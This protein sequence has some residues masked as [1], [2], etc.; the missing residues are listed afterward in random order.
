MSARVCGTVR[1]APKLYHPTQVIH[2]G[3][4]GALMTMDRRGVPKGRSV[5]YLERQSRGRGH[6][7]RDSHPLADCPLPSTTIMPRLHLAKTQT[8][9]NFA[10]IESGPV[11]QQ[12]KTVLSTTRHTFDPNVLEPTAFGITYCWPDLLS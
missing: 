12:P 9:P 4:L 6:C 8:K 7:I 5:N 10:A 1:R 3:Y 11:C 2:V